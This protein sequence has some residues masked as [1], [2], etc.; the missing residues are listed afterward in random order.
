MTAPKNRRELFDAI[1]ALMD[2]GWYDLP[3]SYGGTGGPGRYLEDLLE[4]TA[5]SKD[6]PDSEAGWELKWYTTRTSLI[7]LF[8]KTPDGPQ[9]VMRYL[10]RKH[11]WRDAKGRMSFRHTI[12]GKSDRFRVS[13]DAGRITVRPIKGNG[14]VP[15]WSLDELTAAVGGKL[16]RLLLVR[17]ERKAGQI[18]F[19]RAEA[20][21]T[22]LLSEVAYELVTG[23]IAIDFDARE[24]RPSSPGLRDHGTKFR[25]PPDSVCRLYAKKE[26]L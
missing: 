18:R 5:G 14:L 12:K 17:G 2:H 10:V 19:V 11:G 1:R 15:F 16:R 7:T 3:A 13:E 26:R 21:E 25:L 6:V 22:F 20:F 24:A 9:N 8:H 4:L 23:G